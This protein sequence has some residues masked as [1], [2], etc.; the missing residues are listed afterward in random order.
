MISYE[1]ESWKEYFKIYD[2]WNYLMKNLKHVGINRSMEF[3][4]QNLI[5]FAGQDLSKVSAKAI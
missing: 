5:P 1:R 4:F 2:P 3:K